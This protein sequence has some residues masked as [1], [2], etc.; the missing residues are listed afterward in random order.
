MAKLSW[1][2]Y[3]AVCV[4]SALGPLVH[5]FCTQPG[6]ED[7]SSD[8]SSLQNAFDD[9][10]FTYQVD[11]AFYGHIHYYSRCVFLPGGCFCP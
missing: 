5:V 11:L 6:A 7:P 2:L 10:F 9:L 3:K 8:A 1:V 4:V